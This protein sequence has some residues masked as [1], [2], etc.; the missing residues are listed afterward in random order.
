MNS[1]ICVGLS[2]FIS[3]FSLSFYINKYRLKSIS[4]NTNNTIIEVNSS[5]Y[6]SI[7]IELIH[8]K[9][10]QHN[11]LINNDDIITKAVK[12][13]NED[14]YIYIQ[15]EFMPNSTIYDYIASVYSRVWDE[16]VQCNKIDMN[17]IVIGDIMDSGLIT[18]NELYNTTKLDAI[19]TFNIMNANLVKENRL[20]SGLSDIDIIN[21]TNENTINDENIY[22]IEENSSNLPKFNNIVLGGTFD[23]LHNGHRKLITFS[24]IQCTKTLTIGIYI[25]YFHFFIISTNHIKYIII[26]VTSDEML[27]KKNNASQITSFKNRKL[28]VNKFLKFIKPNLNTNIIEIFD[29]FG[30]TISDPD[31]EA[32]VV[33][34]ETLNGAIKINKIRKE[35]GF[36]K[37]AILLTRRGEGFVLSSTFIRNFKSKSK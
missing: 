35:K 13:T 17:C 8:P 29:P 30:P 2:I 20:S 19:Y 1:D 36:N 14:I 25:L 31:L 11:I 3:T 7:L 33:S 23:Q 9:F 12:D 15:S 26:G 22:Y 18:R 24:A 5:K 21:T 10:D 16:M 34:S 27:S 32:I 4:A 28:Y 6:N 37:L